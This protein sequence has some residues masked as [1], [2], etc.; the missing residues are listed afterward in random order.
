MSYNCTLYVTTSDRNKL[1]K[2]LSSAMSFEM[3]LKEPSDVLHPVIRVNTSTNLS[4]YNYAHIERYG[5]YYYIEKIETTPNNF[6]EITMTVDPLMTYKDYI[7]RVS[8]TIT[9]SETIF[10]AYLNDP[11]YNAES[12]RKY[13]TKRF[14]NAIDDDCFILMTVG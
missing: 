2:S 12:Y 8:G 10:D 5:R 9:R 11:N 6:W 14:P 4:G 1:T 13:V 7:E 3:V